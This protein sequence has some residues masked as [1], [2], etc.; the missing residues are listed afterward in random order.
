MTEESAYLFEN[1]KEK[2]ESGGK[3]G[4]FDHATLAEAAKLRSAGEDYAVTHLHN[5]DE[6]KAQLQHIHE[7]GKMGKGAKVRDKRITAVE[8]E[9]RALHLSLE[10][11]A[12]AAK[13]M[14]E[15]WEVAKEK[16]A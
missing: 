6:E 13:R 4:L 12:N 10:Q 7:Q 14:D 1:K 16:T 9:I 5:I 2:R 15:E 11:L 3:A 8:G